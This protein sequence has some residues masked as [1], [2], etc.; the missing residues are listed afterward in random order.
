MAIVVLVAKNTKIADDVAE[1]CL[2]PRRPA[3]G[4]DGND[5][6]RGRHLGDRTS[7]KPSSRAP[8]VKGQHTCPGAQSTCTVL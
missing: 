8:S 5:P 1:R 2:G 6:G 7:S 4:V 3:A